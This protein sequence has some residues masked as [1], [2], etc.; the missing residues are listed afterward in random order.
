MLG[1]SGFI[2]Y[3]AQGYFE[4]MVVRYHNVYGP[5]MGFRHVIPH[6]AERFSR[7]ERPFKFMDMIRLGPSTTLMMR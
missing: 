1:E 4:A 2:N 7:D 6:L 3:A 5:G